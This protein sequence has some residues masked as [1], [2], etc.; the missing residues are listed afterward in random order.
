M[1]P[2]GDH[3]DAWNPHFGLPLADHSSWIHDDRLEIDDDNEK[4]RDF[5]YLQ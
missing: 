2:A 1:Q 3:Q 5:F 4:V